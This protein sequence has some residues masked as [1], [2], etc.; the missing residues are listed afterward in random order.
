ME[1]KIYYIL[2]LIFVILRSNITVIKLN[3]KVGQAKPNSYLGS[4]LGSKGV[5][6]SDFCASF[7]SIKTIKAGTLVP[8]LVYI[9]ADRTFSIH[10]KQPTVINLLKKFLCLDNSLSFDSITTVSSSVVLKIAELKLPDLNT[11]DIN[12]AK[13][14]IIGC[15]KSAGIKYIG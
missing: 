10:L 14:T 12:K 6:I 9:N 5:N 15:A 7:N 8:V 1:K 3:L 4:C 2:F 11:S 13:K